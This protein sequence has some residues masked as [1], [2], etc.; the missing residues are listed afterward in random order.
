MHP[1]VKGISAVHPQDNPQE[2][3][4]ESSEKAAAK[5]KKASKESSGA[6]PP[7]AF[8]SYVPF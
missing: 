3:G 4:A 8:V 7:K 1:Q 2:A 5:K 6:P